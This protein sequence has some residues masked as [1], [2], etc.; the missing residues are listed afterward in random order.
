MKCVVIFILLIAANNTPA[1][2]CTGSLGDPIVYISFGFG[3]NAGAPLDRVQTS[4]EY[5]QEMCPQQS[6]YSLINRTNNC[7]ENAWHTISGD[8]TSTDGKGFFMLVNSQSNKGNAFVYNA[9]NLCPNTTYEFAVW[10]KNALSFSACEGVGVD[11]DL[12]LT[13]ETK[14]G[15]ILA[16]YNTGSIKKRLDPDWTQFAVLFKSPEAQ[17]DIILRISNTAPDGCGNVFALDDIT[18]RPCGPKV[19]AVVSATGLSEIEVCE[20]GIHSFLLS[21]NVAS[22]F[23]NPVFQWQKRSPTVSWQDIPGANSKNYQTPAETSGTSFYRMVI[24]Q[25]N[26]FGLSGCRISSNEVTVN[27]QKPPTVQ[28]TSYLYGCLGGSITLLA[29]GANSYVWTGPNG[30]TSTIQMPVL[31][32]IQYAAAGLYKVTGTTIS[33]CQNTDSTTLKVYPNAKATSSMGTTI[34]EGSSTTLSAGGGVRYQWQPAKGLSNDSAQNPIASPEDNT[35]YSVR[36]TNEYGCSDTSSIKIAVWKKPVADAGP[37][38]KTRLGFPVVLKGSAKG[39][40]VTWFWTPANDLSATTQLNPT[41]NPPQTTTY[42]L[43]VNSSH[44]CGTASDDVQVKVFDKIIIPNAFSP[45]ADGI[46]D[47][48]NIELLELFN[49][50][51]INVYNRYGQVVFHSRGYSTQWN[52]TRNGD[53]LPVGTYYYIIDLK[54]NKEPVFKGSVTIIR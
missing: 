43:H 12:K 48:W 36:V 39:S 19:N 24:A 27:I 3:S 51:D 21:S 50:A 29:S 11:P 41:S 34:C 13:V 6:Q 8:H 52:G 5:S 53:P 25:A 31:T 37:D 15:D 54:I 33:G 1:Q 35:S 44:G 9:R 46:N 42:T 14:T 17:T 10:V 2:I 47:T 18:L 26:S 16:S 45:N 32:N 38:L 49:D 23:I 20:G 30:F 4:Y 28:A 22:E 7:F 40:D